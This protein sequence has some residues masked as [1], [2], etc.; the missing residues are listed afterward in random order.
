MAHTIKSPEEIDKMRVAGR[1]AADVLHM[2]RPHV[3][4]GITTG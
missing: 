1:L 2:I 3:Q 4:P